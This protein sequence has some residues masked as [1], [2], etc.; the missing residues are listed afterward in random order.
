MYLKATDG[1]CKNTFVPFPKQLIR[2]FSSFLFFLLFHALNHQNHTIV[3]PTK[4][5]NNIST[6]Q[7]FNLIIVQSL[8][9]C[10]A[11]PTARIGQF[12]CDWTHKSA[13]F[14]TKFQCKILVKN[15]ILQVNFATLE[16][17]YATLSRIYLFNRY[18]ESA[19]PW[20]LGGVEKSN[21]PLDIGTRVRTAIRTYLMIYQSHRV[22]VADFKG[23]LWFDTVI[24]VPLLWSVPRLVVCRQHLP[25]PLLG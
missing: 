13:K 3:S 4:E 18:E 16:L 5:R 10:Q 17:V 20:T 15:R 14:W 12:P 7:E 25:T 11:Y 6:L 8:K 19:W 1:S 2:I 9:N 21:P 22:A 24:R 23:W